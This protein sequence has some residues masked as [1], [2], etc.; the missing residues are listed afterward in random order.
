MGPEDRHSTSLPPDII[1]KLFAVSKRMD[2]NIRTY[3]KE[4]TG[5]YVIP[6]NRADVRNS[7]IGMVVGES[8]DCTFVYFG[9]LTFECFPK[10]KEDETPTRKVPS[11][12]TKDGISLMPRF[13]PQ[14]QELHSRYEDYFKVAKKMAFIEG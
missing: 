8:A 6:D 2:K 3:V 14:L 4:H 11:I 7:E 13:Y 1:Y 5:K 9:N 10:Y 12:V